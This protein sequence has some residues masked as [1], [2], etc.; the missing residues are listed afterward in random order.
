MTRKP[1]R[2]LF[3]FDWIGPQGRDFQLSLGKETVIMGVL[4]LTPDSFYDGGAYPTVEAAV[5]RAMEMESA[6]AGIIDIGGESS[7]PGSR[8]IPLEEELG[9]VIPV[10]KSLAERLEIPISIDT[11]KA[12]VACQ[13][14]KAGA[15]IINDISALCVDPDLAPLVAAESGPYIMMHMQ[16]RPGTMQARPS[17]RDVLGEIKNFFRERIEWAEGEGIVPA[18]IIIDPGIGFGKT[19]EH[20]LEIISGLPSLAELGRPILIGPS[21]KSFIGS[22]LGREPDDRLWGTAGAVASCIAGG[23]QIIRVH[24]VKEMK[25]L[26]VVMDRVRKVDGWQLTVDGG[27]PPLS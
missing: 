27:K 20:N 4:N 12:G 5:S 9:R 13:A 8:A 6:G 1:V 22:I 24:D 15:R 21:R 17:Y 2:R 10:I 18:R 19:L 23:A 11:C 26:A 7:R 14:L 3:Q 16:G 25:D